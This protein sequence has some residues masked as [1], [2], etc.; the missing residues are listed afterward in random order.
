MSCNQSDGDVT[1]ERRVELPADPERVW[2]ELPTLL[3]DEV[4]LVA[5]PGGMVRTSGPDGG[6][7]GVVDEVVPAER[8]AF[9]W[10]STDDADAPPSEVEITL[11]PS[12]VGT[13]L[14]LRETRLDGAHLER[15]A[16]TASA[17]ALARA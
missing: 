7:I 3:G 14:H 16:F 17:S 5:E 2:D 8:L 1:I 12:G 9:R 11:E 4:E 15:A 10:V 6:R 13:I